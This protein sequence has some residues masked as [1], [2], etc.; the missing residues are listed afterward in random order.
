MVAEADQYR[1]QY[2]NGVYNGG[3]NCFNSSE[4]T[5]DTHALQ[6]REWEMKVYNQMQASSAADADYLFVARKAQ[7]QQ[8]T[9]NHLPL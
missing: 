1:A 9:C 5:I 2:P 3:D 8:I 4:S 6:Y 7:V